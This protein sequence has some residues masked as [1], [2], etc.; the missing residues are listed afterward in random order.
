MLSYSRIIPCKWVHTHTQKRGATRSNNIVYLGKKGLRNGMIP[1]KKRSLENFPWPAKNLQQNSERITQHV[2]RIHLEE[3]LRLQV[4][5]L[6]F[7]QGLPVA[8]GICYNHGTNLESVCFE[9]ARS[10]HCLCADFGDFR[11]VGQVLGCQWFLILS[12]ESWSTGSVTWATKPGQAQAPVHK[13]RVELLVLRWIFL[14]C[15]DGTMIMSRG[16]DLGQ[17]CSGKAQGG[18]GTDG[19]QFQSWLLRSPGC[20]MALRE[21]V[22]FFGLCVL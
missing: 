20:W 21:G 19:F 17:K 8:L 16:P 5:F 18:E 7:F 12:E 6:I 9:S 4:E 13:G 2:L 11:G 10:K 1:E 3:A 15:V 14:R 22:C